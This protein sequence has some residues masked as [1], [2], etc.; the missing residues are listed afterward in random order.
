MAKAVT[1][2][3]VAALAG[4]STSTVSNLLNGRISRMSAATRARIELAMS[5]LGYQANHAARQLKTGQ[6]PIIGLVIP[7]V[8]NPFWGAFVQAVEEA[9]MARGYQVL[10]GNGGRDPRREQRY[11]ESLWSHGVR[12]VIFGSS[13]L[14]L[15]YILRLV[16]RGLHVM[17]FD[18]RLHEGDTVMDGISVDNRVGGYLATRH[19]LD[20]GHRRIGFLSGP[21]RTSSRLERLEGYR[22]ALIDAEI[23]HDPALIWVGESPTGAGDV[24]GAEIGRT[25]ARALLS[26]EHPPTGLVAINDLYAL[27]AYAGAHDLGF[28]I[29]EDV[30][31]VGFDDITMADMANPPLTTIKQPIDSMMQSAVGT[32]IDRLE[33]TRSGPAHVV[34]VP[35]EIVVRNSTA[36]PGS[37]PYRPD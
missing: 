21:L 35:I 22:N 3:E 25:G 11:A 34:T 12:G 26:A 17:V 1:I 32:L 20:L 18:R 2:Q 9:A 8:A 4:V 5:Q 27:G 24:E 37:R 36:Q 19:L 29:P 7:S 23:R 10:L 6:S 15:D 31:I 16:E 13:P 30:S 14:S 28:R 33:G